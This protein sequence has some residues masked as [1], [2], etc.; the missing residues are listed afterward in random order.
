MVRFFNIVGLVM[1]MSLPLHAVVT[2]NAVVVAVVDGDTLRVKY[3][4]R[5]ES[6]RLIGVDTPESRR[7]QKLMRDVYRTKRDVNT[8]LELGV[9]AKTYVESTVKRDDKLV[10][11][12]DIQRRDHYRRL[13]AYVYLANGKMLNEELILAGH[14]MP[15]TVPPNVRYQDRFY[16]DYR[17]ARGR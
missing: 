13:L 8:I 10:L 16:E 9:A 17:R 2:E 11:E 7:N 5:R 6:V 4:G 3:N 15:M 1:M 12:F 14:A